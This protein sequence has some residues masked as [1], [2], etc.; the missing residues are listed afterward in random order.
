MFFS[1]KKA[2]LMISA[3]FLLYIF[4]LVSLERINLYLTFKYKMP[5]VIFKYLLLL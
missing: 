3:R 5:V 4:F 2:Q 1:F